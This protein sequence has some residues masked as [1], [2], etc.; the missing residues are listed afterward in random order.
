MNPAALIGQT[1]GAS[2]SAHIWAVIVLTVALAVYYGWQVV[3]ALLMLVAA[4]QSRNTMLAAYL[5]AGLIVLF[6]FVA[7]F[8]VFRG[9][10]WSL[11]LFQIGVVLSGIQL[12]LL[13]PATWEFFALVAANPRAR[14][15]IELR[16][17]LA[18]LSPIVL[19]AVALYSAIIVY[20][21]IYSIK[22]GEG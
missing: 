5:P 2:R 6:F 11:F 12:L 4:G 3:S 14:E 16:G 17:Y 13:T 22:G 19:F 8:A 18:F 7:A 10:R 1:S 15:G 20:Q 21:K 9:Y